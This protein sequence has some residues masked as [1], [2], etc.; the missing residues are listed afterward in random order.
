[1]SNVKLKVDQARRAIGHC[2][3][4]AISLLLGVPAYIWMKIGRRECGET[5][6]VPVELPHP[7]ERVG[8]ADMSDGLVHDQHTATKSEVAQ[9]AAVRAAVKARLAAQGWGRSREASP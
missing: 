3:G 4:L 6:V 5:P 2:R 7:S 9:L 8:A 1:M